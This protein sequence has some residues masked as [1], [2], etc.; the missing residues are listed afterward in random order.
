VLVSRREPGAVLHDPEQVAA[1]MVRL[2]TDGVITAIDGS[3]V[4]LRADSICVHGDSPGA[5]EMARA[6]RTRLERAG[7]TLKPFAD[8]AVAAM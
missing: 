1:R 6:V 8:A 2:V 5:I 7:V 3:D 4:T